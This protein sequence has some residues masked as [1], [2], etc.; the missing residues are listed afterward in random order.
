MIGTC[1]AYYF[2][3]R[4]IGSPPGLQGIGKFWI[5]TSCQQIFYKAY[6]I[7]VEDSCVNRQPFVIALY[8]YQLTFS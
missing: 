1:F 2:H 6:R 7:N 8:F 3:P 4:E 5:G